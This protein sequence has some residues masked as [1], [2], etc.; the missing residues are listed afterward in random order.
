MNGPSGPP[1]RIS[2]S[3]AAGLGAQ[4]VIGK[5][6][7]LFTPPDL[8]RIYLHGILAYDEALAITAFEQAFVSTAT[9]IELGDGAVIDTPVRHHWAQSGTGLAVDRPTVVYGGSASARASFELVLTA[10]DGTLAGER[11]FPVAIVETEREAL[12][13]LT[14]LR[15]RHARDSIFPR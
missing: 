10:I 14:I 5:H 2:S 15:T 11:R 7:V 12:F 8:T 6:R 4:R 13:E 1:R 3:S 9:L